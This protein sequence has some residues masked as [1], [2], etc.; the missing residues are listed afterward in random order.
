VGVSISL[1]FGFTGMTRIAVVLGAS[2]P[3]SLLTVVYARENDL[4][5]QF[6]ASMLSL[7][8]PVSLVF[9]SLLLFLSH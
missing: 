9:S 1:L 4:D 6:L 8:L 3:A 2:L 7:A 5:A